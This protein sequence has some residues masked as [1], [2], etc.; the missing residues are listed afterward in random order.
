MDNF[1]K[2]LLNEQDLNAYESFLAEIKSEKDIMS[3]LLNESVGKTVKITLPFNDKM[4]VRCGTLV[5]A[6]K[7]RLV[8]KLNTSRSIFIC[9][10]EDVKYITIIGQS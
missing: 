2:N 10:T 6:D 3:R 9:R 4:C 8:I 5:K 7:G 1:P